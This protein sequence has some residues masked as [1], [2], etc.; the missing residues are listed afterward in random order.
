MQ[1]KQAFTYR[2]DQ[3]Y[4]QRNIE[5]KVTK[6]GECFRNVKGYCNTYENLGRNVSVALVFGLRSWDTS[7]TY[8]Y[9]YLVKDSDTGE[10]SDPQYSRHTFVELHSWSLSDYEKECK[11]FEEN[12]NVHPAEEFAYYYVLKYKKQLLAAMKFIKSQGHCKLTDAEIKEVCYTDPEQHIE[13][14]KYGKK[15][16]E[17]LNIG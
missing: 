3:N 17:P 6:A 8:G 16:I 10:Y 9:H 2:Y 14:P 7:C 12:H 5:H 13:I 15:E 4:F 1:I 11:E